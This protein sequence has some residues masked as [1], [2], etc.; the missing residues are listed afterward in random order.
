MAVEHL[1]LP[2]HEMEYVR[3]CISEGRY[4]NEREVVLAGLH[5]LERQEATER[6]KL[7]RFRAEVQK[8]MDDLEN[9]RYID[10]HGPEGLQAFFDDI[11]REA[12]QI[13]RNES[14]DFR[15]PEIQ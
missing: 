1:D 8:G 11:N 13:L 9:G 3:R 7:E 15:A 5:L 12:D 2:A 14:V 6:A 4:G 10:V